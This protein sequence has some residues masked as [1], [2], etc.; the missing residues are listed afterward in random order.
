[1]PAQRQARDDD[2]VEAGVGPPG[3][4]R[5]TGGTDSD[6]LLDEDLPDAEEPD[7]TEPGR[8]LVQVRNNADLAALAEHARGA[9]VGCDN[10]V[11]LYGDAGVG[12]GI[13]AAGRP[14]T[15]HGG[16]GGEVGHMVVNPAGKPCSCGSHGCWETE[17]G[18]HA[19]LTAA[20]RD[21]STGREG[22]L[23]VVDAAGRGDASA[24]AAVRQVGDWL[25]FGVANLVNI[26]NPEMVI[27]GGTL[28]EVYLA[29]AA[30]VRSRLNRNALPAC[31][32][33]VRLRTPVLGEDAALLGAAELAFEPLFAD[34]LD[35]A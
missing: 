25:G 15:G 27:F 10:V 29:S 9:A 32:E 13:I 14:V 6:D 23:A 11:Y 20:G 33:H 1:M 30:Q 2:L 19:L 5:R 26:F 34:P 28:R 16:Y 35:F 12:G 24:Q 22:I 17:I 7:L 18:E 21:P 8:P 3:A 31:R 4:A